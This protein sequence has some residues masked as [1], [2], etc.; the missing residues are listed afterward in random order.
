VIEL[1]TTPLG[2]G[3]VFGTVG[4]ISG[5]VYYCCKGSKYAVP[6]I[7]LGCSQ[8]HTWG[9]GVS[10]KGRVKIELSIE[11]VDATDFDGAAR[12][13]WTGKARVYKG[14]KGGKALKSND[15]VPKQ[16]WT[17]G[18][19]LY[20]EADP[21]GGNITLT[22]SL[23]E[24]GKCG[25]STTQPWD[26]AIVRVTE[27]TLELKD[28]KGTGAAVPWLVIPNERKY[29]AVL[30]A[31]PGT[32]DFAWTAKESKKGIALV[33]GKNDQPTV[34]LAPKHNAVGDVDL[35]VS[36]TRDERT[37]TAKKTVRVHR[38]VIK[39]GDGTSAAA[40]HALVGTVGEDLDVARA[41][42]VAFDPP[43]ASKDPAWT[44]GVGAYEITKGEEKKTPVTIRATKAG[45]AKIKVTAKLDANPHDQEGEAEH[46]FE[47]VD[48]TIEKVDHEQDAPVLV[49]RKQPYRAE[50]QVE[51][52]TTT[53]TYDEK[54]Q[55]VGEARKASI[56]LAG[57]LATE[58]EA[59]LPVKMAYELERQTA[60]RA[61]DV[62]LVDLAV[63][64][65]A[66][67]VERP[68]GSSI[69]LTGENAQGLKH[70]WTLTENPNEATVEGADQ[71]KLV[72]SAKKPGLVRAKLTLKDKKL[73]EDLT[74]E[75][76]ALFVGVRVASL[77]PENGSAKTFAEDSK[78]SDQKVE[79][80][81]GLDRDPP[82]WKV[83]ELVAEAIGAP[84]EAKVEGLPEGEGK[85]DRWKP[86][87]GGYLK[88]APE[89]P[90]EHGANHP[91]ARFL[92]R[93]KKGTDGPTDEHEDVSEAA[94]ITYKLAGTEAK[95]TF[96]VRVHRYGCRQVTW[97]RK[98]K[99]DLLEGDRI[100]VCTHRGYGARQWSGKDDWTAPPGGTKTTE[101]AGILTPGGHQ[102]GGRCAACSGAANEHTGASPRH[103]WHHLPVSTRALDKARALSDAV[104]RYAANELDIVKEFEGFLRP[105][106]R[107]YLF[108]EKWD[109]DK[110][111]YVTSPSKM[112]G[113]LFGTKDSKSYWMAAL[114]GDWEAVGSWVHPISEGLGKDRRIIKNFD[115]SST[116]YD[117]AQ[118]PFTVLEDEYGKL[119]RCAAPALLDY[120][121]RTGYTNLE[122][123]EV[124][125]SIPSGGTGFTHNDEIGSCEQCRRILGRML[126]EVG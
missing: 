97:E 103:V 73:L 16:F 2:M 9:G 115:G 104:Q 88:L 108:R 77:T 4:L 98:G 60:T 75:G 28:E 118:N 99:D 67:G 43:H 30:T 58:E 25:V 47:I 7:K 3:L 17:T 51:G 31:A 95:D 50:P 13:S 20:L 42:G 94:T 121:R 49:Q 114:S 41:F 45:K 125:V 80:L 46:A 40:K 117:K 33:K 66:T 54:L 81:L 69:P 109:K 5:S 48:P 37:L 27:V 102:H 120:A 91:K 83:G 32:G 76:A 62:E 15:D 96:G 85:Y 74:A 68:D 55:L 124:W 61:I 105:K 52:A 1:V 90:D 110:K 126:C 39:D 24:T 53:F 6:K 12:L 86:A 14:P 113:V 34:T 36:W 116:T 72:I 89:Q 29:K 122:L 82:V 107:T 26:T 93:P 56:T 35:T 111:E 92:V 106:L 70:A 79:V 10:P 23:A 87:S 119:G 38:L 19:P 59:R 101:V 11:D 65:V 64:P 18:T 123:A 21:E 71:P 100:E 22:F 112:L 63:T 84:A 8:L 78:P 57:T 44:K